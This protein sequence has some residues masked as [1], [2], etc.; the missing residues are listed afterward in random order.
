MIVADTSVWIDALRGRDTRE[1]RLLRAA[2]EDDVLLLG[3]LVLCELL[4]GVP[5][6][7]RA[8]ALERDLREHRIASM[9]SPELAAAAARNYRRLRALGVTV[10]GLVDLLIG[11]FC[12]AGGHAL[13]HSDRDFLPMQKHLGLRAI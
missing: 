7:V 9:A 6:E 10:S 5:D 13:L 1:T 2:V 8:A 11:T 12:I 3:D 4:L